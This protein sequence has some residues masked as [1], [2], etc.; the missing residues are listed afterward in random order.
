MSNVCH[1]MDIVYA[2]FRDATVNNKK[3][4]REEALLFDPPSYLPSSLSQIIHN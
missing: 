4:T 3:V 2:N 1:G